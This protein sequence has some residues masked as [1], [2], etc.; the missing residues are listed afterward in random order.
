M[1]ERSEPEAGCGLSVQNGRETFFFC[2]HDSESFL[3]DNCTSCSLLGE[4]G[5]KGKKALFPLGKGGSA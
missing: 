4:T 2:L 1:R 3:F 5:V